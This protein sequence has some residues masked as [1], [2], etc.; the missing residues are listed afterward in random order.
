MANVLVENIKAAKHKRG[1][2]TAELARRA[3]TSKQ[4]LYDILKGRNRNPS[5]R[6]VA[7]L[8]AALDVPIEQLFP[9]G[10]S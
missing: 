2:S 9:E 10:Q 3:G 1:I 7:Q 6:L 8:A 5:A 4:N